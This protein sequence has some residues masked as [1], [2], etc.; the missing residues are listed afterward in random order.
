MSKLDDK[1]KD[2][3]RAC[4]GVDDALIKLKESE[5]TKQLGDVHAQTLRG[6]LEEA[7]RRLIDAKVVM[8]AAAIRLSEEIDSTVAG[9]VHSREESWKVYDAA[10][11]VVSTCKAALTAA[12]SAYDSE[13]VD[14][15][16]RLKTVVEAQQAVMGAVKRRGLAG[17][18]LRPL[19][20]SEVAGYCGRPL[21]RSEPA[22]EPTPEPEESVLEAQPCP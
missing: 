7:G 10:R 21:G 18:V 20:A 5:E 13:S 17:D 6:T 14:A 16:K 2:F 4:V 8:E 15:N 12:Q 1:M 3:D 22:P 11:E 9:R 19:I